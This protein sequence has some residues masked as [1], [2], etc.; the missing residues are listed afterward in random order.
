MKIKSGSVHMYNLGGSVA[1][2]HKGAF[3]LVDPHS[4]LTPSHQISRVQMGNL[5]FL[6]V[7]GTFLNTNLV[8]SKPMVF[9]LI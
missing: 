1:F 8:I 7:G 3:E 9:S 6:C 4:L 2:G 5:F